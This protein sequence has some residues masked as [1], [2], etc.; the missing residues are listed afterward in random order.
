VAGAVALEVELDELLDDELLVLLLPHAVKPTTT[1]SAA[2]P[3]AIKNLNLP[4][5]VPLIRRLLLVVGISISKRT[6]TPI[7]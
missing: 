7:T 6:R 3:L 1:A 4:D 5:I 2:E